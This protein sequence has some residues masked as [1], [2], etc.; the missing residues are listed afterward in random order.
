MTTAL[1]IIKASLREIGIL[2]SSE[3]PESDD[4]QDAL[5]KLNRMVAA[6][7]LDGIAIG[8]QTW[9]LTSTIPL[10]ENHIQSLICN[11]ATRLAPDYGAVAVLSP[12][13]QK[14]AA[15]GYRAL[16]AAYGDP[17]DMSI[18]SALRRRNYWGTQ[19]L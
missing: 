15:D 9:V 8:A 6:W 2:A 1:D 3:S 4:A 16:Q 11:L 12:V 18:D 13:T 7:E 10:P 19:W 14:L 5:S 17:I